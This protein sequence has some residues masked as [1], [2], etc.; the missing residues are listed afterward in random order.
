MKKELANYPLGRSAIASY[1][2]EQLLLRE[3]KIDLE[4]IY[5]PFIGE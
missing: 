4:H 2:K 5:G 3:K 1:E